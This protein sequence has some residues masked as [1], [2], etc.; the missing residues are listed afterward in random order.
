MEK[1][2]INTVLFGL[3]GVIVDTRQ[4]HD[5][6]WN[7]VAAASGLK[8]DNFASLIDGMTSNSIIELYFSIC[9]QEEKQRIKD[10]LDQL[11]INV[12]Y[13]P[14]I[15]KGLVEYLKYLKTNNYKIGLVTSSSRKKVSEV[16]KQLE[17]EDYF[18]TVI[19]AES[20]KKGKPDPMGFVLAQNNLAVSN[21]ECAVFEDAFTGIKAA[22]Y[23]FMRVIG[24][25]TTLSVDFL[26]DYTY[27]VV[28]DFS[29]LENLKKLLQ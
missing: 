16:F 1:R 17:I 10:D 24:V 28:T 5:N 22:T 13:R 3:D 18:D 23:A 11:D 19:T 9:S 14:L 26:K 8:Y 12:D 4:I 21:L 7:G 20:I 6:Y 25:A 27:S 15:L 29:D 2:K